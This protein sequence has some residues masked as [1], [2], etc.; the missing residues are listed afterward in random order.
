MMMA[1]KHWLQVISLSDDHCK[2]SLTTHLP[3]VILSPH[4][5]AGDSVKFYFFTFGRG[6][7]QSMLITLGN[8]RNG[9]TPRGI[10]QLVILLF[11]AMILHYLP[12]GLWLESSKCILERTTWCMWQPSKLVLE[13]SL[14]QSQSLRCCCPRNLKFEL[15]HSCSHYLNTTWIK[16]LKD[17][18]VLAGGMLVARTFDSLIIR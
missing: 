9:I 1:L 10:L 7:P 3:T 4:F 11:S 5:A 15:S 2:L 17:C 14:A 12:D 6:G 8:S 16:I 13:S 18:P